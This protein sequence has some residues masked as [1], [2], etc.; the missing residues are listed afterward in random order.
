MKKDL[1]RIDILQTNPDVVMED[2][3]GRQFRTKLKDNLA[4][5]AVFAIQPDGSF[6]QQGEMGI[7]NAASF[8]EKDRLNK[9]METLGVNKGFKNI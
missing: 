4:H 6:I 2:E 5:F 9:Y 7:I 3:R 8:P 1:E